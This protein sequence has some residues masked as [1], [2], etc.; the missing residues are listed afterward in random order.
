MS[1]RTIVVASHSKLDLQ[2]GFL[3]IRNAESSKRVI[4]DE[5]DV[6]L[7]ESTAVSLTAALLAELIERKVKVIFCNRQRNPMAELVPY[8]GCHDCTRRL[9]VQLGW[10]IESKANIWREIVKEKIRNQSALLRRVG[11][12][13]AAR[14]LTLYADAVLP[15]DVTNREGLSAREYFSALFGSDFSREKRCDVN[16]ALDYGYQVMLSVFTRELSCEGYLT[17]LGIFHDN[18]Y[19]SFNFASDLIEPFR[20]YVDDV[21]R[22]YFM[23]VGAEFDKDARRSL[24]NLLHREVELDGKRQSMINA[25]TLY[26]RSV[27]TA[28]CENDTL[29][30]RFPTFEC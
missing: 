15:G 2:V 25:I 23:N 29:R 28:L 6:L 21:V 27:T 16:S 17:Q 3:Q 4:L 11:K 10:G 18:T 20:P 24:V 12:S 14:L 1:W 7:I 19:N 9:R 8:H 26:V 30:L 22:T 5:I 13:E